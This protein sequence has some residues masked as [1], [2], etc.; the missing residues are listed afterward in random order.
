M[1]RHVE[2]DAFERYQVYLS[3]FAFLAQTQDVKLSFSIFRY[4]RNLRFMANAFAS[5]IIAQIDDSGVNCGKLRY[6]ILWLEG[7]RN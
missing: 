4:Q 1:E 7:L 6:L 5:A 2:F 3:L